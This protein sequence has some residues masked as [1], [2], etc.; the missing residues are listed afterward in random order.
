LVDDLTRI[1]KDPTTTNF[2]YRSTLVKTLAGNRCEYI[3]ITSKDKD[4]KS[5][6]ALAKKG[7]FI[8]S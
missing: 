5:E 1:E 6:K 3:C 4:P 2:F 8:S 7:V